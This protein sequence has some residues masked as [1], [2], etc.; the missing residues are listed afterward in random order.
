MR[1]HTGDKPYICQECGKTFNRKQGLDS[2][3]L[4]HSGKRDDKVAS[5]GKPHICTECGIRV[6]RLH[7]LIKHM[8]EVHKKCDDPILLE[9]AKQQA[10][11]RKDDKVIKGV[12]Y[13]CNVCDT[14]FQSNLKL[15]QHMKVHAFQYICSV[16]S[17]AFMLRS[18]LEAHS[19]FHTGSVRLHSCSHPG[20]TRSFNRPEHARAHYMRAHT[21]ERPYQCEVCL[22]GFCQS[23]DLKVH[24]RY[25]TGERPYDC[26]FCD[27]SFAASSA[28]KGHMRRHTG[29]RPY[30]CAVCQ[31]GYYTSTELN[32]CSKR[33]CV[34]L[35]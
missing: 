15:K 1:I 27:K 3:L 31:N 26:S 18:Q 13:A 28:L 5:D 35:G 12:I 30:C 16:C 29:E 8:W 17:R 7:I 25:H 23:G 19:R 33:L 20:C 24:M 21:T 10:K 2:H 34:A 6:T 9:Q 32:Q 22:K 4:C 14:K 11:L